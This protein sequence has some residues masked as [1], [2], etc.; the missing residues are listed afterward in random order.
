YRSADMRR[1]LIVDD[2]ADIRRLIRM[3]L[4]FEP[5]AYD[6]VISLEVLS[7]VADQRLFLRKL[8]SLTASGGSLMLATQNRPV[9]QNFN[10]VDPLQPGQLRRWVDRHELETLIAEAEFEVRD[11]QPISPRA[12]RLP[13][14]LIAGHRAR[15]VLRALS[16]RHAER[17]LAR[18]GLAWTLMALARKR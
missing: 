9:L 16:G 2:H 4:E 13:L 3:T 11:I 17:L 12:N 7:H 6:V 1:I 8:A 14:S 5:A 18:M 10:T 15:R